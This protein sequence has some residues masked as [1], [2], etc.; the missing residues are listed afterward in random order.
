MNSEAPGNSDGDYDA[1]TDGTSASHA[2]P[3]LALASAITFAQHPLSEILTSRS[4]SP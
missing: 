3:I 4:D 1:L 2:E